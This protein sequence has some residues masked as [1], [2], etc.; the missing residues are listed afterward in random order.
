MDTP[1]GNDYLL[2]LQYY[3]ET[4]QDDEAK[5]YEEYLRENGLMPAQV[6]HRAL[7]PEQL[8]RLAKAQGE[9]NAADKVGLGDYFSSTVLEPLATVAAGV[10]GAKL[11]ASKLGSKLSG[12][13]MENTQRE[14][15]AR[16]SD[17]PY[18]SKAAQMVG[19]M[20]LTPV[21]PASAVRA[22]ALL[23]GADQALNNDPD[24]SII[25]RVLRGVA[26]ATV[27]GLTGKALDGAMT[28]VRARMTPTLGSQALAQKEATNQADE[29]M[30]GA[31]KLQGMNKP[32][33]AEV[34]QAFNAP[35]ISPYVQAVRNTR[36]FANA[37]DATVLREAYKLMSEHQQRL[38]NA[39]ADAADFKAG[40]TLQRN[41]A[42]LA[43]EQLRDA[44]ET[45]MPAFP[46]AVAGHAENAGV[47]N[48]IGQGADAA[49][50][51]MGYAQPAGDRLHLD[52]PEAFSKAFKS[53]T[54]EEQLAALRGALGRVRD[55][56]KITANPF[57]VYGFGSSAL[58][59]GRAAPVVQELDQLAGNKAPNIIQKLILSLGAAQA[60]P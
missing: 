41:E 53:M 10:P 49:Q 36:Q 2:R 4:G 17:V 52:T 15:N 44:G 40:S 30:Y 38:G 60:R 45:M 28:A 8:Q 25:G 39:I 27:G 54:R 35:D 51:A 33:T 3:R 48:A 26:G 24:A 29:M 9:K 32:A 37:D 42:G 11:L 50:V 5:R 59:A 14:I 12:D 20:A 1:K 43:K 16:T 13:T 47:Q 18:A 46:E 6:T 7:T 57:S 55:N 19:T 56:L 58:R 22:G 34:Q 23:G 31:A 21:L